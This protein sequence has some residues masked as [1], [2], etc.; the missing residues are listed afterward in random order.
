MPIR[1]RSEARSGGVAV[2]VVHLGLVR[3]AGG[4]LALTATLV[5]ARALGPQQ[6]GAYSFVIALVA[7]LALPVRN[8]LSTLTVRE[9]A[10]AER[11]G[12][13]GLMKGVW[14]WSFWSAGGAALLAG[15][16]LILVMVVLGERLGPDRRLIAWGPFLLLPLCW[17]GVLGAALAGQQ[18]VAL[19]RL[20]EN[21]FR[22]GLLL[23]L[24]GVFTYCFAVPLS[25]ATAMAVTIAAAWLSL[26]AALLLRR[27]SQPSALVQI[28][29]TYRIR[30]WIN[31]VW[32]LTLLGGAQA[33]N[34][35]VD[36]VMLGVLAAPEDV[37]L[38][39][40]VVQSVTVVIVGQQIVNM[41]IAPR[42]ARLHVAGELQQ[43][44]RLVTSSARANFAAAL[45][46][47][48][49]LLFFG[50]VLLTFVFG[51]AYAQ[52]ATA[53]A[54]LCFGQL[55]NAAVGPVGVLLNMSGHERDTLIGVSMASGANV[56]LNL[57]LIPFLGLLGAAIA[58]AATLAIW[59]M[60]LMRQVK[61]R[62]G[63]VSAVV[64]LQS[65][66]TRP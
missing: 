65:H 16:L 37:G 22:P 41:V 12:E 52:G 63:V 17:I 57:L 62:L 60:L 51:A 21:V 23:L 27:V 59:N 49:A 42:L 28:R 25:A 9:T 10:R 47:A 13:L 43:L 8:G 32:P 50:E 64:D 33:L 24:L 55:L 54:V 2:G 7:L 34:M 44:Q 66:G 30:H 19:G 15:M 61:N 26:L 48:L 39:R 38:Y 40:V 58:S 3:F 1:W 45:V 31:A 56:I 20:P 6:Y 14:R 18:K 4:T 5:L 36:V 53:L 35:H 29:A 11:L 46:P